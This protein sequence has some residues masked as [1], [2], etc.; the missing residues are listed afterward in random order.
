MPFDTSQAML[1]HGFKGVVVDTLAQ[2][3]LLVGA[4]VILTSA[5][6]VVERLSRL[7]LTRAFGWWSVLW[8]GWI[9]VPIHE[10]SH[11]VACKIFGHRISSLSLFSPDPRSG[12]LGYVSHTWDHRSRYQRAGNFFIGIAPVAGGAAAVILLTRL[13]LP[14]PG[15]IDAGSNVLAD[16]LSAPSTQTAL[17]LA[18]HYGLDL[19][20]ALLAPHAITSWRLWVILYLVMAI[21]LHMS[22]SRED[23]RGTWHWFGYIAA[24]LLTINLVALPFGGVP[25]SALHAASLVVAPAAAAL[26]MALAL[27][28]VVLGLVFTLTQVARQLKSREK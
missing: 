14:V 18:L 19:P 20:R 4:F 15:I 9:G 6:G 28:I 5:H 1:L 22:P 26:L 24:G 12:T 11:L 25:D 7:L 17:A 2:A 10:M 16:F 3:F 23:L 13:A 27:N 8:T 21:G